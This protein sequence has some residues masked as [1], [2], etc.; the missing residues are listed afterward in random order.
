MGSQF[1]VYFTMTRE[2]LV[3]GVKQL[4][5]LDPPSVSREM[6]TAHT[7]VLSFHQEPGP[8]TFTSGSHVFRQTSWKQ[9]CRQTFL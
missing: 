5:P 3:T 6:N 8:S 2:D 9:F 4:V 7:T 1:R